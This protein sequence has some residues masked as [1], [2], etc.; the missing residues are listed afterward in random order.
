MPSV[1]R[2][3]EGLTKFVTPS[4]KFVLDKLLVILRLRKFI[5]LKLESHRIDSSWALGKILSQLFRS[6]Y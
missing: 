1:F 5:F 4:P 3:D 6:V 2:F